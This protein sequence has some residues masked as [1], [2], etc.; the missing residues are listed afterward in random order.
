MRARGPDSYGEWYSPDG[1]VGLG[2]RRLAIIEL[3]ALGA[4]PMSTDD[5]QLHVSFNGE[6]YNYQALRDELIKC[7]VPFRSHS[8]TEVLLH[9]YRR[10]GDNMVRRLRGMFAFSIWDERERKLFLARDP[11]GIKPLYY[12]DDGRTFRFASQVKALLAGGAVQRQLD[13]GGVTGFFLWGSVPEPRT[14][15]SG[16]RCLPAGSSM[17]VGLGHCASPRRYWDL[18]ETI[19]RSTV[20][21]RTV[22]AGAEL[23]HVRE[24]LLDSV[25][26]HMVADVPVGAFLSAG[27]DSS[28]LVG[29]ARDLTGEPLR[30]V[31]LTFDDFVGK[32]TD[33]LPLAR[34][35]A[36][37][38][39]VNHTAV[40]LTMNEVEADLPVFFAAMDQPTIDGM[41]TWFVSKATAQAGLKVALSGL[42]GDELL[43]GYPSFQRIP[44]MVAKYGQHKW[45]QQLGRAYRRSHA[46]LSPHWGFLDPVRAGIWEL[47]GTFNGAYQLH[48]G[49]FMPW[50]LPQVLQTD[51][52][53]EGL[54]RLQADAAE[55]SG[56]AAALNDFG[57]VVNLESSRYMRNQLL[58]DTD[59][60]SMAHSLEVRVPLVDS[61]LTERIVGLAALGRL[62]DGKSILP[63]TLTRPLPQSVLTKPKTGFTVPLWKWLRKSTE[64]DAWKSVRPLQRD[65]AHDYKRLTYSILA[66][67]PELQPVL[68]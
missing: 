4:Q 35:I 10:E 21:A 60:V 41:N 31:T 46:F 3:S 58:R 14:L 40:T 62:G 20:S 53:L 13:P 61:E 19:V 33:E 27:L 29:L 66:R 34:E 54:R 65:N 1:R 7:G 50:E 39:D 52:A 42:G 8:D 17:S 28:T 18:S 43:G 9:L 32:P 25:R 55:D 38:L 6:I 64:L 59:W 12:A 36:C 63:A 48:R 56:S 2:H 30:T 51:F 11:Y 16:I 57:Q 44:N 67:S 68:K 5:G 15:Y 45:P 26:A 23:Q 49:V 37:H 24:A 22:P 47:G